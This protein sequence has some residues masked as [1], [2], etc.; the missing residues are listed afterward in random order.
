MADKMMRIAGR[1]Y[2]NGQA[3]ALRTNA[4]GRLQVNNEPT[5]KL[6]NDATLPPN[7]YVGSGLLQRDGYKYSLIEFVF[8]GSYT[9]EIRYYRQPLEEE[10]SQL[11]LLTS[12]TYKYEGEGLKHH[13]LEFELLTDIYS[14]RITNNNNKT[15]SVR[16]KDT[17]ETLSNY[18]QI[19]SKIE[20][21]V[22]EY[23]RVKTT[24]YITRNLFDEDVSFTPNSYKKTIKKSLG[25]RNLS[26]SIYFEGDF[27]VIFKN[28]RVD[29]SGR[30]YAIETD[31][32]IIKTCKG[33]RHHLLNFTLK[34]DY[35]LIEFKNISNG[36]FTLFKD[37]TIE[38]LTP[39]P[40]IIDKDI[41]KRL[42]RKKF[43]GGNLRFSKSPID[44]DVACIGYDGYF[45][46]IDSNGT[47]KKYKTIT[48]DVEPIETGI[49][50]D[51]DL[52]SGS[53]SSY[54]G[55]QKIIV[56]PEGITVFC[57][58]QQVAKIYHLSD[59]NSQPELVYSF[60]NGIWWRGFGIDS[61][62]N[63]MESLI[64]AGVYGWGRANRELILSKN[65]GKTFEVI[66]TTT[67]VATDGYNSHWHDVSI[68]YWHGV[69]W[70]S[71]GDGPE[72]RRLWYSHDLGKTWTLVKDGGQ[73]TA[74]IPF[75]D[76]VVLGRDSQSVG[77]DYIQITT[78]GIEWTQLQAFPL[79][80]FKNWSAYKYYAF[81]PVAK[82]GE[83]YLSFYLYDDS[84]VPTIIGTG[85]HGNSWHILFMGIKTNQ[86]KLFAM[87]DKYIYAYSDD[88]V[89]F[90]E[91]PEWE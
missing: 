72:N 89:L 25:N 71:E 79:Q 48:E 67:N 8:E 33:K 3:K 66:K 29:P 11:Q 12:K 4:E 82:G 23:G 21:A 61:Y 74:I 52:Y 44:I 50:F 73:P 24:S 35:Y 9:L 37:D 41:E 84:T 49:T 22:D 83:A 7:G 13:Q 10:G 43:P 69:L 5:R 85:D 38:T 58:K 36:T 75:S 59:I 80:E 40:Q 53:G 27:Q 81:S 47:L 55:L 18:R 19:S 76:K 15:V 30:F 86:Q 20:S 28:L 56:M 68:D 60:E 77:L 78:I 54:D 6:W 46:V 39:T 26:L 31:E 32:E 57:T 51:K 1:D 90:A 87:D 14:Y 17:N 70:A 64:L 2:D 45:Y 16:H 34:S 63:G 62:H 42:V 65:G 91:K 88:G